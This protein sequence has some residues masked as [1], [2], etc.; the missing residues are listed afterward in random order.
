[1]PILS[2]VVIHFPDR[3]EIPMQVAAPVIEPAAAAHSAARA[4]TSPLHVLMDLWE[5]D[6]V[7]EDDA[8]DDVSA[9]LC[10]MIDLPSVIEHQD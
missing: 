6:C 1:M 2:P 10:R 4:R 9:M 8:G 5:R 3:E 7:D